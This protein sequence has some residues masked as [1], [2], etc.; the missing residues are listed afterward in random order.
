VYRVV[1]SHGETQFNLNK[2]GCKFWFS[3]KKKLIYL[4]WSLINVKN[5]NIDWQK[6]FLRN[7]QRYTE[8]RLKRFTLSPTSR[9]SKRWMKLCL[10]NIHDET[11]KKLR[12]IYTK[13]SFQ[14]FSTLRWKIFKYKNICFLELPTIVPYIAR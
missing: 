1:R 4:S 8:K 9:T 14:Y 7:R 11:E 10:K 5:R 12:W 13:L 2:I 6:L 3:V